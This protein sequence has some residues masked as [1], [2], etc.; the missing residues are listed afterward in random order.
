M[1]VVTADPAAQSALT[2]RHYYIAKAPTSPEQLNES[3][4][5][6]KKRHVF[7]FAYEDTGKTVYF[8]ARIENQ[9]G[10]KRP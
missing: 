3:E 10:D 7:D 6:R 8:R 4:F 5:T 1:T 9:K 2:G